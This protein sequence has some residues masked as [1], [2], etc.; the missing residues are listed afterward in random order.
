[1]LY[2]WMRTNS[3]QL[4]WAALL[5]LL[6]AGCG[7]LLPPEPAPTLPPTAPPLPW[8]DASLVMAGICFEAAYDAAGQVFTLRSADDH[9]H[10]YDL[11]DNSGLCRHPVVRH[12]FD[13]TGGRVLVGLWSAGRGCTARHDLLS[14]TRDDAARTITM[15]LALVI[16]GDCPYDLVRPF[17]A[18]LDAAS[19][20]TITLTVE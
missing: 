13:F 12:P 18:G 2:G 10:L 3:P 20:Y 9:I 7:P 8:Q 11:A 16:E 17:W 6:A 4:F 19:D 1:M 5:L 14:F 15:R